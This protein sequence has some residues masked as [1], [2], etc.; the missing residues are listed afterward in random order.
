MTVRD[1]CLEVTGLVVAALA[2]LGT[3]SGWK[4][5]ESTKYG[6][7]VQYP[8]S[9]HLLT[10]EL[11]PTL[12]FLSILNFHPAQRVQG[13]V[14]RES[15]AEITVIGPPPDVR[16]TEDWIQL[17]LK[18]SEEI[19]RVDIRMTKSEKNGCSNLLKV[20]SRSE[21]GPGRYFVHTHLYCTTQ[22]GLF[23]LTL[24][25]WNG[26]PNQ[27]KLQGLA[28]KIVSSLRTFDVVRNAAN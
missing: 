17:N 10:T 20:V 26:D 1:L 4:T 22:R 13:I 12:E 8:A 11:H 9:W 27:S 15:G 25:N 28:L 24:T 18:S 14:L 19:E 6:Y 16:T 23:C 5:F 2:L 7:V 21:V 3:P